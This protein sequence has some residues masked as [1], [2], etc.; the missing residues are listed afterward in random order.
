MSAFKFKKLILFLHRWLGFISGLVVFIVSITGCI[1]CFQDEILDSFYSYR[2]VEIQ[3][4]PFVSPSQLQ[5]EAKQIYPDGKIT[6]VIFY[7][8]SRSAQVRVLQDKKIHALFYN[9]YTAT[10]LHDEIMEDQFFAFIKEVHLHLFLPAEI[11]KMVNGI[12]VI[13]FIIIMISGLV[14]WWPKRKSDRK[15]CFKIKWNG[16]WKRVNYDLHNVLGFY[17]TSF[18]VI[19]AITGLSFSFQW[20]RQGIYNT[21]NLGKTYP[22]DVKFKSDSINKLNYPDSLFTIDRA[23]SFAR[24]NSPQANAFLIYPGR[25]SG[26]PINI[27]AYPKPLHF[28]YNENYSFDRY[29]GKMLDFK[30][31]KRKNAGAKINAMNYDIH[32]G[33]ILGLFGKIIAFLV[34]LISATLPVTGL[35][36]YLGKK[37]KPKK[38]RSK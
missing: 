24:L 27:S 16:K 6:L 5:A 25:K 31:Y 2:K 4:K 34:S 11:G 30:S 21:A 13:I 3:Q 32:T 7:G 20:V 33:Q 23:F 29:S 38:V 35:I 17:I 14:L 36:L 26:A 19:L 18:A 1:Y 22:S 12:C 28:S 10:F 37:Y 9:P 15:R 8:K